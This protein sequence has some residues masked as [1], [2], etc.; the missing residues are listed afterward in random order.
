MRVSLRILIAL[1]V[2]ALLVQ[3]WL[4]QGVVTP[5][6]VAG[7]SMAPGLV[8]EHYH[9]VCDTCDRPF[10]CGQESLPPSGRALCPSCGSW[11]DLE[12]DDLRPGERL[13]VD[14]T[15]FLRSAPSRWTRVVCPLPEDPQ[16]LCVKRVVGL[17][18]ENITLSDGD[19]YADGEILRKDWDM[20]S[21]MAVM[22][23]A[24]DYHPPS[25]DAA[26]RWRPEGEVSR[27]HATAKGFEI[28][29]EAPSVDPGDP[30]DWLSYRHE[31]IWRQGDQV[32]R[33]A[34]PILD[35]LAYNQNESRE[36]ISVP[37]VVLRCRLESAGDGDVFFRASDGR[38]EFVVRLDLA[39]RR[40]EVRE[41]TEVVAQFDLPGSI[42]LEQAHP[43]GLALAD[44]RLQLFISNVPIVDYRYD[45]ADCS[46]RRP[47]AEP[48][49]IGAAGLGLRFS[50]WVVSRDI[51]YLPPPGKLAI[52]GR[53]LGPTEYWLAGDNTAISDDSR[54]WPAE[55]RM[56]R[57]ALVG[58]IL[59]WR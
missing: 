48:L 36:L 31:Q 32:A 7:G 59:H 25:G 11:C 29:R 15:A 53:Q 1:A 56:T 35:D 20:L 21:V 58:G 19:V 26:P 43:V 39:G 55:V 37:D 14:R 40:G 28:E 44:C 3:T 5:V 13:F 33:R 23:D 52:E 9:V 12:A 22:V 46:P 2:V 17:P 38:K 27:W 51:Y 50:D 10:D 4:V 49:A 42:S 16:A 57:D 34:G 24:A 54:T 45:P 18:G 6:V 8:G 47:T 30:I 41:G